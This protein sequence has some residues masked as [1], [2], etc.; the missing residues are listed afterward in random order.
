M[1]AVMCISYTILIKSSLMNVNVN[2]LSWEYYKSYCKDSSSM[3]Y[4]FYMEDIVATM[5]SNCA[6]CNVHN[7]VAIKFKKN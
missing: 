3:S 7:P 4:Y 6:N 2:S 5:Y 1:F